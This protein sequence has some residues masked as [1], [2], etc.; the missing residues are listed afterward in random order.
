MT[1]FFSSPASVFSVEYDYEATT[2]STFPDLKMNPVQKI[3]QTFLFKIKV[4]AF[5]S[6]PA[7]VFLVEYNYEATTKSTFPD[8]KMNP[9]HV[10]KSQLVQNC[11]YSAITLINLGVC[12]NT[13]CPYHFVIYFST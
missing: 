8:L 3:Q 11:S 1:A 4:T 12:I 13:Q 5:F 6:S 9:V 7:S 10:L 2:K